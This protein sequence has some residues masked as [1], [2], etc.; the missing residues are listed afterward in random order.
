M[1]SGEDLPWVEQVFGIEGALHALLQ[2]DHRIAL[3]LGQEAPFG[4]AHA[5]LAGDGP[6]EA[7]G[8][9]DRLLDGGLSA[10]PLLRAAKEEVH[11]QVAVAGVAVAGGLEAVLLADA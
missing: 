3:L 4:Q 10:R 7:D 2:S 5:V 8:G 1:R 9:L 6:P 11:V